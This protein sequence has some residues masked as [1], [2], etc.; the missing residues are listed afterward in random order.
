VKKFFTKDLYG[1]KKIINEIIAA[2]K[3]GAIPMKDCLKKSDQ[4]KL[5]MV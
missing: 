4:Q 3:F 1:S 5:P 2:V